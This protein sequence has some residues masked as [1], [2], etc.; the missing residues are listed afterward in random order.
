MGTFWRRRSFFFLKIY[1]I[2]YLLGAADLPYGQVKRYLFS[3]DY[4]T[5]VCP[6]AKCR[7]YYT[8]RKSHKIHL[9][10]Q[11]RNRYRV[12]SHVPSAPFCVLIYIYIYIYIYMYIYA[13]STWVTPSFRWVFLWRRRSSVSVWRWHC[14]ISRLIN[15]IICVISSGLWFTHDRA[16]V[17]LV[18]TLLWT[19]YKYQS[20]IFFLST[21]SCRNAHI[22]CAISIPFF[23]CPPIRVTAP[24]LSPSPCVRPSE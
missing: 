22:N 7:I 15:R 8:G 6:S 13:P 21:E 18:P 5:M 19:L 10:V 11:A 9:T 12:K 14:Y 16:C 2:E 3:K 1:K 17:T 24:Y 20:S 4:L 23:T